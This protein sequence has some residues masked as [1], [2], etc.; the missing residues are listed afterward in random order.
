MPTEL[1]GFEAAYR[2]RGHGG[3]RASGSQWQQ[4]MGAPIGR[5][6]KADIPMRAVPLG[7]RDVIMGR[8]DHWEREHGDHVVHVVPRAPT[9]PRPPRPRRRDAARLDG[10]T[11]GDPVNPEFR[12]YCSGDGFLRF[13]S[14]SAHG[15]HVL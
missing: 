6:A 9:P 15:T 3:R 7:R 5:P 8:W 11:P 1:R 14:Q 12:A 4:P 10:M 2:A 13:L